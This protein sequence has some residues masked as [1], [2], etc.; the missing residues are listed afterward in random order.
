LSDEQEVV[1]NAFLDNEDL[2]RVVGHA[3]EGFAHF[4]PRAFDHSCQRMRELHDL[5]P[6]LRFPFERGLYPTVTINGGPQTATHEHADVG[7][8]PGHPCFV[9]SAGNYDHTKS[10]RFIMHDLR[11]VVDFPPYRTILVSSAGVRHSNT[12]LQAGE[13]RYSIAG[14]MTGS[15]MRYAAYG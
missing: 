5:L 8:S 7:N 12:P 2:R 6:D 4:F 15:L 11:L 13:T 1:A 10:A 3:G 14:Y 9:Y